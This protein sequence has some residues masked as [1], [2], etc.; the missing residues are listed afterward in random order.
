[1]RVKR[2]GAYEYCIDK[3]GAKGNLGWHQNHSAI[4]IQ[5]AAEAYLLRGESIEHYIRNHT[6]IMD[7]M[8]RTKVPRTSR[9]MLGDRQVQNVTRYFISTDGEELVKIM[10]PLPKKPGVERRIGINVGWKAT[11]CNRLPAVGQVD[12]RYYIQEAEKLVKPLISNS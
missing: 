7:F 5:K 11:E 4:I 1:M 8:L 9:L 10:P 12:Y 6:D 3:P 2:K